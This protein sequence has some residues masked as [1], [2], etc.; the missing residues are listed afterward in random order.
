MIRDKRELNERKPEIDL[1]GP[2][3]NAFVLLG[4]AKQ[5]AKQLDKDWKAIQVEM[6]SGDYENLLGVLER[7]FGEY[8]ILY[9]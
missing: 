2:D 4:Y 3:G 8:I 7:E 1:S 9:R 6:M 5:W